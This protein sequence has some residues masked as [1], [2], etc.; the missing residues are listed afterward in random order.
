MGNTNEREE[1]RLGSSRGRR[2][3][4]TVVRATR[5]GRRPTEAVRGS[6]T[7]G[8]PSLSHPLRIFSSASPAEAKKQLR[9]AT[10][11]KRRTS[12]QMTMFE[13]APTV[14]GAFPGPADQ[15]NTTITTIDLFAGAGGLSLGF[16]LA[17]LGYPP[18]FAVEHEPAAA[19]TFERNFG[20]DVFAGDIEERTRLSRGRP[21]HRRSAVPGLQPAGP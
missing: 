16:H 11:P 12:K 10:V 19:R 18:V 7:G 4:R 6:S 8:W 15:S 20:C 21:H 3:S 5:L 14:R 17:D 1:A 9:G 2:T 13:E